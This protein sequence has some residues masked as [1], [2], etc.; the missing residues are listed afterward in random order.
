M[1]FNEN[2]LGIT[3]PNSSGNYVPPNTANPAAN[4]QVASYPVGNNVLK[5]SWPIPAY[6]Q[7]NYAGPTPKPAFPL[8][9]GVD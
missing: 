2:P 4:S 7:P 1:A 6:T 3:G 8:S 5:V 9:S